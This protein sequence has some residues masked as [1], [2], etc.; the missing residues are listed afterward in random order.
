MFDPAFPHGTPDG[1]RK[2]CHGSHCPAT[3]ACRDAHRRYQGDWLFRTRIDKGWTVEQIHAQEEQDRAADR[4]K[5]RLEARRGRKR[6]KPAERPTR[7]VAP[8]KLLIPRDV[9]TQMHGQGM[10]DAQ[11]GAAL[12]FTR[13]Q[14]YDARSTLGLPLNRGIHNST[15]RS[16]AAHVRELCQQGLTDKQIAERLG[17]SWRSIPGIR[18]GL[19]LPANKKPTIAEQIIDLHRH[20][21]TN[22]V[23]AAT[24]NVK[25]QY[26]RR[27]LSIAGLKYNLTPAQAGV[28]SSVGEHR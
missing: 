14:V 7:T 4:L 10:T 3:I 26:V 11:I 1:F 9:L 13:K 6:P 8:E 23:I 24:L 16:S 21:L 17:L 27:R 25:P 20:G 5:L 12:G 28:S 2:G 19:G 22:S 15:Q 18:R